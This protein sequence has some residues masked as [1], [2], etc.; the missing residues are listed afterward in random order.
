MVFLIFG[1]LVF[2]GTHSLR[3]SGDGR[4]NALLSR[5]GEARY[6]CRAFG[7]R[8]GPGGVWLWLGP[9]YARGGVEPT[10]KFTAS[11]ICVDAGVHGAPGGGLRS[12]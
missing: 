4:R 5:W 12:G 6:I 11:R 8:A 7:V 10:C 9:R 3:V 1:L 2:L